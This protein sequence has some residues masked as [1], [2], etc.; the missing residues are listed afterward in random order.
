MKYINKFNEQVE[1]SIEDWCRQY[2][3]AK[4]EIV[5]G[6][7]NVNGYV[8]M[9]A[10]KLEKIHIQFGIV[11]G[12][13]DFFSNNLTSLKGCP[14]EV[15]DFFKCNKNKLTTLEGAPKK[16]GG[17]FLCEENLL[18]SLQGSPEKIPVD[19]NCSFNTLLSLQ[20]G[21]N[22]VGKIFSCQ[23]N[24]LLSLQGGPIK[25]GSYNCYTNR[26]F[27]LDGSP[28]KIVTSFDCS[29]NP[30]YEVYRLFG[31]YERYKASLDYKYLRGTDIVRGR[32][33]R[34]CEDAEIKMPNSIRDYKYID[35]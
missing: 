32:F 28:E 2:D 10:R 33:K 27:S 29:F 30:I 6:V 18:T 34:A 35:L 31:T 8:Y 4:Y 16:V 12:T 5:D 1:K 24:K 22:E 17:S 21:P 13:F 26:L 19:F 15:G 20:G 9:P 7:V 23:F 14:V 25:V 11:K 3:M